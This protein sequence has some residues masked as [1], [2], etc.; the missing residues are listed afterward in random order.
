MLTLTTDNRLSHPDVKRLV[1]GYSGGLDSHVL[2]HLA[3]RAGTGLP[4]QALH[5]NHGLAGEADAWQ[6]HC[7]RTCS[8][9]DIPFEAIQ[10]YVDTTAGS[11]EDKARNA[12]FDAFEQFLERGDL[13]LLAHHLDDQIETLFFYLFRGSSIFGVKGMPPERAL[14]RGQLYRPLLNVSRADLS[15]YAEKHDLRWIEDAS[16]TDVGPDRNYLR[17]KVIPVIK[18]RWQNLDS[19]LLRAIQ[20][21]AEMMQLIDYYGDCDL[22]AVMSPDGGVFVG[23]LRDMPATR[24]KNI[25][26]SW[27]RRLNLPWPGDSMLEETLTSLIHAEEGAMPL[28][29]WQGI[30]LHRFKDRLYLTRKLEDHDISQ[31]VRM[32]PGET[33]DIAGGTLSAE[34]VK[35]Q[36]LCIDESTELTVKFRQGGERIKLSKTRTLKNLYQELS[37][38][39]WL[40]QRLPLVY[41]DEELVA[42]AGL[43][44]WNVPMIVA[45]DY[46]A[47]ANQAGW[48]FLF[49]LP[50]RPNLH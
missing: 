17:H 24:S 41:L 32:N 39:P 7:K 49:N 43:P 11:L 25:I 18:A 5:I 3:S 42:V 6:R 8:N 48:L 46:I 33:I 22:E 16:N 30:E 29:T 38:P 47:S 20:R 12:R 50:D 10:V 31:S 44:A 1:I 4:V 14:G 2:L 34:K 37:V 15:V 27:V 13:L 35:G 26:R 9:L 40:R 23:A 19:V 21:D 45:F 36:G 28:L